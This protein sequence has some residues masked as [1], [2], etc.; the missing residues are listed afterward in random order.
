M[1][2]LRNI[3]QKTLPPHFTIKNETVE[4]YL[5][6][7]KVD[8]DN[9]LEKQEQKVKVSKSDLRAIQELKRRDIVIK[10]ADKIL[11]IAVLNHF[12]AMTGGFNPGESD[13]YK[14]KF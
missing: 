11:G 4:N 12:T 7:T 5:E 13:A 8:L 10:T 6:H 1:R 3:P 14:K 9:Y 2:F